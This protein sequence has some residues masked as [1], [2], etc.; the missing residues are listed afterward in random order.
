[1]IIKETT[2]TDAIE[3]NEYG[4][5]YINPYYGCSAGCPFCYWLS[6]PGWEGKI[7][8]RTNIAEC[9]EDYCKREGNR[10]RVYFGS[11]CDPYMEEVEPKYR[12]MKECLEVLHHYQVPVSICTSARSKIVLED[13]DQFLKMKDLVITTELC[14][15]DQI[16]RM[17]RGQE[18]TGVWVSNEL[19]KA[20]VKVI[21]TF[22]PIMPGITDVMQIRRELNEEIPIYI[23]RMFV[24]K[25]TIQAQ[26]IL[27]CVANWDAALLPG[28]EAYLDGKKPEFDGVL[29]QYLG[30]NNICAFPIPE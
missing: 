26:R 3:I 21:A 28:Y 27:E 14:R 11:Y 4:Q 9:I 16:K 1:M 10:K 23:D 6:F 22:A 18:H 13:L 5:S 24:E 30:R 20:G 25:N 2:V 8:V 19:H 29:E 12:L 15:L 7:E 17:N